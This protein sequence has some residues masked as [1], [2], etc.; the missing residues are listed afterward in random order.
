M[1][2]P[3]EAHILDHGKGKISFLH[4]CMVTVYIYNKSFI[5]QIQDDYSFKYLLVRRH[6]RVI[7]CIETSVSRVLQY[8][9]QKSFGI[10][11][12][13]CKQQKS[14]SDIQAHSQTMHTVEEY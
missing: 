14:Y 3:S 10:E 1:M 6:W 5:V 9:T 2:Y 13:A 8:K 4:L 7:I 12:I 11:F